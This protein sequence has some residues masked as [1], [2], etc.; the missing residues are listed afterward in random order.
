M[1]HLFIY[2]FTEFIAPSESPCAGSYHRACHF[3]PNF[4]HLPS[5]I[6]FLIFWPHMGHMGS[7]FFNQGL[8][9]CSL[10]WKCR[11]LTTGPPGLSFPPC[12]RIRKFPPLTQGVPHLSIKVCFYPRHLP[13]SFS[14]KISSYRLRNILKNNIPSFCVHTYTKMGSYSPYPYIAFVSTDF[15]IVGIFSWQ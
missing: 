7:W 12:F 6:L 14:Q 8:K 9:P 4:I 13:E 3:P 11:V 5:P 10:K 15:Y 1:N 2:L